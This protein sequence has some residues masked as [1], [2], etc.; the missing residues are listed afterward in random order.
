MLSLSLKPY[1]NTRSTGMPTG[2]PHPLLVWQQ[3][4]QWLAGWMAGLLIGC[5]LLVLFFSDAPC[6]LS[7]CPNWCCHMLRDIFLDVKRPQFNVGK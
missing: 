7:C 1:P 3:T 5:Y 2:C 4:S 6:C